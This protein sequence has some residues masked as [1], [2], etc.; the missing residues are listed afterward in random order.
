MQCIEILCAAST[1]VNFGESLYCGLLVLYLA[2]GVLRCIG[3]WC[4]GGE[5]VVYHFLATPARP[6]SQN[7]ATASQATRL[8][9][10]N[11]TVDHSSADQIKSKSH[12]KADQKSNFISA[13]G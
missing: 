1:R 8:I 3:A 9:S 6:G 10:Q 5:G 2:L 7:N 13:H 11:F 12:I 4:S